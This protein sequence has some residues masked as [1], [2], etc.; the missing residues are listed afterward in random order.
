MVLRT[1]IFYLLLGV[2]DVF[3]FRMNSFDLP[4]ASFGA[5]ALCDS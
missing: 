3:L 2:L 4:Q 5:P 1:S